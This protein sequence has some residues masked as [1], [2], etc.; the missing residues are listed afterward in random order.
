MT[1][2]NVSFRPLTVKFGKT[3]ITIL[4]P[5][6]IWVSAEQI[7][8]DFQATYKPTD[9]T[10]EELTVIELAAK[11]LSYAIENNKKDEHLQLLPV[12]QVVFSHFREQYLKSNDVHAI[13]KNLV[14]EARIAVIKAYFEAYVLLNDQG[15]IEKNIAPKSALFTATEEKRAS[16]FAIFG[17]QG[18]IE[19][20]FDELY[21]NFTIYEGF[22]RPFIQKVAGLLRNLANDDE[23]RIIHTKGLDVLRWLENPESKPDQTYLISAPVSLPLIGLTQLLH[24]YIMIKVLNQTPDQVRKL[25][26]GATGHSQGII[27]AVAIS[28]SGTEEE[29]IINSQKALGLLFWIGTRAHQIYP[30]TTLAPTILQ[31]SISN[32]EGN[33]TPMLSITGLRKGDVLKHI[34]AT[35]SHLPEERQIKLTLTNGPRNFVCT[36]HPQSLYGLNLALRKIKAPTG[37][38]QGRVPHSERKVKFSSRFLPITAPFHS[39]YLSAAS[40]LL[41][42]DIEKYDL[43][44]DV[45]S[46]AIPV[47]STDSGKDLRESER[48]NLDL[49]DQ[50]CSLPVQWET[51]T[52]AVV[53]HILDFG[54]GATSG[55]GALTHRNKE[56]TGVRIFLSGALEGGNAERS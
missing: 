27:S 5:N 41:A 31:D 37:L 48:L 21:E 18:N 45:K 49:I 50:I 12:I 34:E 3:E 35:N 32:N 15:L 13:T 54:P 30:P 16:L 55:I 43:N 14:H 4:I 40:E 10:S 52:N 24:Y 26:S 7:R 51:A 44:F 22:A 23:A 1:A 42:Q 53:T 47:Y 56:G 6:D 46:L 36:G 20:Y 28:A 33:P 8:E 11:F 25:I 29:L 9:P 38:D 17:G 2:S 19:E 39:N